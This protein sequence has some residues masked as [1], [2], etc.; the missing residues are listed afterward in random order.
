MSRSFLPKY[1]TSPFITM[2]K[3]HRQMISP[4]RELVLGAILYHPA[5]VN[6]EQDDRV[7]RG[8]ATSSVRVCCTQW[9]GAAYEKGEIYF[10][11]PKESSLRRSSPGLRSERPS[12][13]VG[14]N[15]LLESVIVNS[16]F[17]ATTG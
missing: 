6:F 10:R 14:M 9:V 4:H 8:R 1:C 13:Y 7:R 17:D 15:P 2:F 3:C 16:I 12:R 11:Q 5:R